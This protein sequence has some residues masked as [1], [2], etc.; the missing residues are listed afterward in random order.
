MTFTSAWLEKILKLFG[1]AW[2]ISVVKNQTETY[3]LKVLLM[4]L[5]LLVNLQD[6]FKNIV[7]LLKLK[8]LLR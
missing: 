6:F 1:I 5:R 4:I 8:K 2:K 3:Q 7:M